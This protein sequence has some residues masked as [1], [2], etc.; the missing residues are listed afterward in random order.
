MCVFSL[1]ITLCVFLLWRR[2]VHLLSMCESHYSLCDYF[3]FVFL[4]I[5]CHDE[6]VVDNYLDSLLQASDGVSQP[7]SPL[8]VPSPSDSGI[9]DDTPSDHLNSPPPPASPLFD[10][11]FL[12]RH[13][14]LLP[15]HLQQQDASVT[16]TEPDIS[17]DL[18]ETALFKQLLT[19]KKTLCY[20]KL[21]LK[22]K[23][24]RSKATFHDFV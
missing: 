6:G 9:S 24:A 23:T 1:C 13:P 8:W 15:Q 18:G 16:N 20:L 3:I 12:P 11:V 2:C 22:N 21:E 7:C 17:I 19:I 14:H 10:T 4:Q 5:L